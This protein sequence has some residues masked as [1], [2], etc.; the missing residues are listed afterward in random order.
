MAQKTATQKQ[1]VMTLEL[2]EP[3]AEWLFSGSLTMSSHK[4]PTTNHKWI[5]KNQGITKISVWIKTSS[6]ATALIIDQ[7]CFWQKI[8]KISQQQ[9]TMWQILRRK[10]Q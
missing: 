1:K 10:E 7:Q 5:I 9:K 6:V 2:H 8:T 4:H 3:K